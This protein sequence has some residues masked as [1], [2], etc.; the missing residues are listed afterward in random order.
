MAGQTHLLPDCR[1]Y[2]VGHAEVGDVV[3]CPETTG[4]IIGG[5]VVATGGIIGGVV[6]PFP[7]TVIVYVVVTHPV[8][9]DLI[10][11]L[12]LPFGTF[13]GTWKATELPLLVSPVMI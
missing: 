3:D 5:V 4:G 12:Y 10:D 2:P 8:L 7:V 1:V 6:A 13:D 9:S 11:T